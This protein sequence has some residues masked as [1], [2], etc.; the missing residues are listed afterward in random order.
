MYGMKVRQVGAGRF[1]GQRDMANAC[2]G[3]PL[4]FASLF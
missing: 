2:I 4:Q 1:A 3:E